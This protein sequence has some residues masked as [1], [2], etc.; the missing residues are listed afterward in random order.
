MTISYTVTE[1]FH[2]TETVESRARNLVVTESFT[3]SDVE[4]DGTV[5]TTAAPPPPPPPNSD[6][7]RQLYEVTATGR[8]ARRVRQWDGTKGVGMPV[9]RQE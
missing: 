7:R 9:R 5:T 8:V 3:I 2:I 6:P 4:D 1:N